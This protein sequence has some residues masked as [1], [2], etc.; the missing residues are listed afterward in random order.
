MFNDKKPEMQQR[1]GVNLAQQGLDPDG[2]PAIGKK[3][4]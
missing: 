3:L 4:K 1:V 2:L